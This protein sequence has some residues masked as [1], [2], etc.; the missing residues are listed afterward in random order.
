MAAQQVPTDPLDLSTEKAERHLDRM[1]DEAIA[2]SFP[3]SDPVSLAMPHE[4]VESPPSRVSQWSAAMRDTWPLMLV[5]G[6]IVA[7]L[8]TRRQGG[9]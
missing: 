4:R 1:L 5:A 3:S 2:D 8:L 7:M 6:I 9:R